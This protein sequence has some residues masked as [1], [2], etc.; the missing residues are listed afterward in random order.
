MPSAPPI[1]VLAKLSQD[2]ST[3]ISFTKWR[4]LHVHVH[5]PPH[6]AAV[7]GD[8]QEEA[9]KYKDK[10]VLSYTLRT[11]KVLFLEVVLSAC[12]WSKWC[13]VFAACWH[14]GGLP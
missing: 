1:S 3:I 2:R 7:V 12:W 10:R 13:K 6:R 4:L 11:G 8:I 5:L 14:S 9:K